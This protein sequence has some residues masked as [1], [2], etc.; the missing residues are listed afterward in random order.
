[1]HGNS[2]RELQEASQR[3]SCPC[4]PPVTPLTG[5]SEA[6]AAPT[7]HQLSHRPCLLPQ[8]PPQP[9]D[10][11]QPAESAEPAQPRR[12]A[13]G[14][15]G[16]APGARSK[17]GRRHLSPLRRRRG[18]SLPLPSAPPAGSPRPQTE[19]KRGP[20]S[21]THLSHHG[22]PPS[23]ATSGAGPPRFLITPGPRPPR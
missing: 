13:P 1:M 5:G 10:R 9:R 20:N 7:P 3:S 18:D 8:G 22:H 4:V 12:A 2:P 21:E 15:A 19:A 11:R 23:T 14:R 6:P 17:L 16:A